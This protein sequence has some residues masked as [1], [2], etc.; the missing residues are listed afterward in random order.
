MLINKRSISIAALVGAISLSPTG[1]LP[2]DALTLAR[3]SSSTL[4]LNTA[5]NTVVA[6][7]SSS[8]STQAAYATSP[9]VSTCTIST[10]LSTKAKFPNSTVSLTSVSGLFVGTEVDVIPGITSGTVIT[11]INTGSNVI[12]ISPG[13]TADIAKDEV[14]TF[15]GCF[16]SFFSVNNKGGIRV[17]SFGISQ[18]VTTSAPNSMVI[19]SCSTTWTESTGDCPSGTITTILSTSSGTSGI[20]QVSR[21]LLAVTGTTR[22]RSYTLVPNRTATISITIQSNLNFRSGIT[23]HS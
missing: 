13:I 11:A 18:S 4:S 17:N 2:A 9:S 14:I 3:A 8:A 20:A 5:I 12:T 7:A 15:K 16:Q 10:T 19:E 23:T 1:L 22:L 6:G 21:I